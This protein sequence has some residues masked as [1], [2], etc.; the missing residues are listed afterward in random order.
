MSYR[1]VL[2]GLQVECDTLAELLACSAAPPPAAVSTVLPATPQRR[3]QKVNTRGQAAGASRSWDLAKAYA[4]RHN[5]RPREARSYL[6]EHPEKIT[7]ASA[8]LA[9]A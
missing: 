2:R 3:A 1:F 7:E 4:K 9:N 6:C 5:M 8:L